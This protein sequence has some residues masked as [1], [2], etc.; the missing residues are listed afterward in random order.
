MGGDKH[1]WISYC[2]T[3][4]ANFSTQ[5]NFQSIAVCLILM[6]TSVC[7]STVADCRA[8]DQKG[9]VSG[10]ANATIFIGAVVGELGMGFLGDFLTR[11]QALSVTLGLAGASAFL[12]AVVPRGGATPVYA[13]II[14]F[15]FFL[16]VGLGGVYPLSATKASE[17]S[18][19]THGQTNSRGSAWAFFWQIPGEVFPWLL[20]YIFT[21][22]NLSTDLRWRLILGLGAIPCLL[23]IGCIWIESV[24]KNEFHGGGV[25]HPPGSKISFAVIKQKLRDPIIRNKLIGCGVS[26]FL[27]DLIFY[28]LTLLGGVV[29]SAISGQSNDV[30]SD[31]SVR[32]FA[33]KQSIALALGAVGIIASIV[34]L[35]YLSL[36]YLTIVG[37]IVQGIFV[38][39]FVGF[40][41]Y[42]KMRNSNGLFA[43]YCLALM[44]LLFGVPV[45]TYALPAAVFEKDIRC[46]FNGI[47]AAMG[48]T[49]AIVGAFTFYY[50]AKA[51]IHA[52]LITCI[53][54]C[55]FGAYVTHA[56]IADRDMKRDDAAGS[57][58]AI[59]GDDD[60]EGTGAEM[61][62]NHTN[63]PLRRQVLEP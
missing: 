25:H 48:K 35:P 51:S 39:F 29:I 62:V 2:S 53:V 41:S 63:S 42:L 10:A 30:S 56:Y 50:I 27:Y 31:P 60:Q 24:R 46:T 1:G 40:F 58:S 37:F 36:K 52:V 8:G 9:W 34:L 44:S 5:Y 6:S 55:A 33:S 14:V 45:G 17:D 20:A 15:R 19:L 18:S 59:P 16:G 11:N 3:A 26:W 12:S 13:L 49:G 61:A 4:L 28:G 21:Y 22:T 32:D 23:S 57:A 47:A 43:L 54:M 7:T 38:A